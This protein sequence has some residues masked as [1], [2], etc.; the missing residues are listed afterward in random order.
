M[1]EI[2]DLE[3]ENVDVVVEDENGYTYGIVVGTPG[4]LLDEM[5]QEKTNFIRPGTPK[6]IVKKL[7]KEIVTEAIKAYAEASNGGYWIKLYQF[8]DAIDISVLNKLGEEHLKE[9]E[10]EEE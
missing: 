4:D 6:I 10:F 1:H 8:A 2:T 5:E 7:T 9:W 3:N